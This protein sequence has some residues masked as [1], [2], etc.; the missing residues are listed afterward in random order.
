MSRKELDSF[1]FL[2]ENLTFWRLAIIPITV[3][4]LLSRIRLILN[5]HS[6]LVSGNAR[7]KAT[8][9]GTTNQRD[10]RMEKISGCVL[11]FLTSVESSH[12]DDQ[13][14]RSNE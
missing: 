14:R 1:T 6:R 4:I 10:E 3:E 9:S 5:S 11:T 8:Q 13:S 2:L 12:S 7:G